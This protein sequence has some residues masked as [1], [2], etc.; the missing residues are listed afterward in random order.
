VRDGIAEASFQVP[1]AKPWSAASPHLHGIVVAT[2]DDDLC[3]RIGFRTIDT[4]TGRFVVNGE[5]VKL[6]GYC[7][8]EAHPQFGPA[9][10]LQQQ[11][12]DLQILRDLGCN[13]IR[14]SHYAQD[15]AFLDL[16]DEMGFYVFEESL[17]WG[18]RD[19]EVIANPAFRSGQLEQTRLM[20][21][22]SFNHPSVILWGYLN[23][24]GSDKPYAVELY[25]DLYRLCKAMDP[26]RPVTYASNVPFD[27][28]CYDYCDIVSINYYPAWYALDRDETRPLHEIEETLDK[29][30]GS[31][32]TAGHGEKPFLLTE[33]GAGAIY[34]W[35]DPLNAHWTEDYQAEYLEIVCKRVVRDGAI[36][37]VSLWQFCDCRTYSSA[38][39]LGRPRAFNNKGTLDEYRRPKLAYRTVKEIFRGARM[40]KE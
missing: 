22:K 36:D 11:I 33:I 40:P 2:P 24:G 39:A 32:R 37:G 13:F 9:V 35:R 27:D 1:D 26:T 38:R 4:S 25:R 21:E 17:G 15:P 8:H 30:L 31:V 7:R 14:G 28:L 18:N 16:C 3:E 19:E 34:G 20:I 5:P 12:Q 29:I 10:P 23:E 6:L